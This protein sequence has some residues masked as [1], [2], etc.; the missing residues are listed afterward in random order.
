MATYNGAVHLR[1]QLGSLT[2]Q[3]RLPDELVITDDGST[4][5][6]VEIAQEFQRTAPFSVRIMRNPENL[7]FTRNF[8]K[9]IMLCKGDLIFLCDQD[10]VWF[11]NKIRL[12]EAEFSRNAHALLIKNNQIVTDSDLRHSG[13][14]ILDH[15]K[16]Q[17]RDP[18]EMVLGCCTAMRASWAR[19]IFP[20][21][22]SIATSPVSGGVTFDGWADELSRFLGRQK[23][24]EDPLQFYRRHGDNVSN[25]RHHNPEA[26]SW[27]TEIE[28]RKPTS[29]QTE[30]QA[31][32]AVL[33]AYAKWLESESKAA[34]LNQREV[35]EALKTIAGERMALAKRVALYQLPRPTRL[36]S[37]ARAWLDGHYRYFNGWKSALNDLVRKE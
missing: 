21:P 35:C 14:S 30:W 37:V 29:P 16:R 23:L 28:D 32:L 34:P 1:A 26:I 7:G 24:I 31:R 33:S 8:E 11:P 20:I 25:A 13:V 2:A 15:L 19:S 36:I 5:A 6:T 3:E 17:G 22:Q 18:A 27:R 12:V 4:D 10:D 9:A